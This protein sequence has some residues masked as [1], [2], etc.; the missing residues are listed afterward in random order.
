MSNYY[1]AYDDATNNV[2]A[3]S[4]SHK[5]VRKYKGKNGKWVYVYKNKDKYADTSQLEVT[6]T[7]KIASRKYSTYMKQDLFDDSYIRRG[8]TRY[9]RGA[10]GRAKNVVSDAVKS[11]S[12]ST[13]KS[14]KKIAKSA[15]GKNFI[16]NFINK[17][18]QERNKA[19]RKAVVEGWNSDKKKSKKK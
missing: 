13:N 7:D 4:R 9:E 2:L 14:K 19:I 5:Y 11:I 10:T 12:K 1:Y 8:T 17:K 18:K 15:R 16:E 6:D 3:H